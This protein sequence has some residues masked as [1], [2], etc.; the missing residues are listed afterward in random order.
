MTSV[1]LDDGNAKNGM[2]MRAGGMSFPRRP[3]NTKQDEADRI[4]TDRSRRSLMGYSKRG[5]NGARYHS[6]DNENK[7]HGNKCKRFEQEIGR[8]GL[9]IEYWRMIGCMHAHARKHKQTHAFP[10]LP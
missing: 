6:G 4:F 7:S 2:L 9:R 5:N 8:H 3:E 10:I 1:C